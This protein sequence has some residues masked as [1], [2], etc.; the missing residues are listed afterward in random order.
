MLIIIGDIFYTKLHTH[1]P[2]CGNFLHSVFLLTAISPG[3]MAPRL[4]PSK[5]VL[6]YDMIES[7]SFTTSEISEEAEYSK[8][9]IISIRNNLRQFG[10]IYARQTRVDRKR[11]DTPDD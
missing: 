4:S 10:S 7:E 8:Q 1:G 11:T 5:I 9:T 3:D 6:I 2:T